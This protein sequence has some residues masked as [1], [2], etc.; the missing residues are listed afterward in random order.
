M[1]VTTPCGGTALASPSRQPSYSAVGGIA[2]G[3]GGG[4][5]EAGMGRCMGG[6]LGRCMG[7]GMGRG[8]G[9]FGG[10]IGD[11]GVGLAR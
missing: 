4:G 5:L 9:G 2:I 7:G 1:T 6:C 8:M 10:G 11:P 3:P